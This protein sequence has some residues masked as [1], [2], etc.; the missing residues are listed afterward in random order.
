M[1]AKGP[2]KESERYLRLVMRNTS[3]V[4]VVLDAVGTIR[5]VSAA[6]E[7][8]LG[9]KPEELVG[10][11]ASGFV[12]SEDAERAR[13]TFSEALRSSGVQTPVNFRLRHADGSWRQEEVLRNNLLADPRAR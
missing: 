3:D 2:S 4:M 13:E 9:Y 10:S 5:Y 8:I 11:E 6:V 7:R 12:H 1:Q